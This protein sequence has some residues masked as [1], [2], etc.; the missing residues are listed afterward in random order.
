MSGEVVIGTRGSALARAQSEWVGRQLE[1]AVEGLTWRLEII[2]TRGDAI[3]NKP[4]AAIG[5]KG[6]FTEEL[7]A[8]L[9]GG[10]IDLAVHSLKDL[11]T[12]MPA[13][14]LVG[15]IPR[16]ADPADVL[17]G[18][19]L[20]ALPKGA[21]VGTGSARRKALL[22]DLRPDLVVKG[23]RGNVDTRLAKLA[24]GQYDAII[25][26]AAG[27]E[28]LG[29]DVGG[30]PLPLESFIPAPGQ[31]ALGIQCRRQDGRTQEALSAIDHAMTRLCCKA[32]RSFL[33]AL[34][35]GCSVPAGALATIRRGELTLNAAFA[36]KGA[37]RRVTVKGGAESS[38][39]LGREAAEALRA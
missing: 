30:D 25:L 33:A 35:G 15:S 8:A 17:V 34:G 31:G 24:E 29:L 13:D 11:P 28:R 7:E 38:G 10:D 19:T 26:A 32:E 9:R 16:R 6:L 27:L 37:V 36:V 4:L 14:L 1:A 18:S 12:D 20:A 3:Q 21:K 5:G 39:E 23:I 22:L 2:R